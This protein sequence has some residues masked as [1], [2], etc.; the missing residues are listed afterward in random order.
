M[1]H[2]PEL[3]CSQHPHGNC[4]QGND[5]CGDLMFFHR[6]GLFYLEDPKGKNQQNES[7]GQLHLP[8]LFVDKFQSQDY[9][10]IGY[11]QCI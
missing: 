8:L 4:K 9:C 2:L 10:Q 3:E 7:D 5:E 11:D 6:K 1:V